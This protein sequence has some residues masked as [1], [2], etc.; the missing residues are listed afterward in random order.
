MYVFISELYSDIY[1]MGR[2]VTPYCK[3]RAF[4]FLGFIHFMDEKRYFLAED[5]NVVF[6]TDNFLHGLECNNE[7]CI[8]RYCFILI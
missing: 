1:N 3:G 5:P 7:I 2:S 4:Y 8:F 6:S